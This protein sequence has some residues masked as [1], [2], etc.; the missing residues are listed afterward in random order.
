MTSE[1]R[2]GVP[3]LVLFAAGLAAG[4]WVAVSPWVLGYAA[5]R[6]WTAPVWNAVTVGGVLVV[7][8]ASS[9]VVVL[10]RAVHVTLRPRSGEPD[11]R[12]GR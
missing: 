3:L 8:S 10:A 5:G 9:L 7:A 12:G 11:E 2:R 4:L 6:G 1:L